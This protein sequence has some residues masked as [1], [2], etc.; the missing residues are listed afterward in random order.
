[1]FYSFHSFIL[2]SIKSQLNYFIQTSESIIFSSFIVFLVTLISIIS[3]LPY[4][5]PKSEIWG[6]GGG[7][8]CFES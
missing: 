3:L 6:G 5:N 8:K 1:M 2:K 7:D 4:N